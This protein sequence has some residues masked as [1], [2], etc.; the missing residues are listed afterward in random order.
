MFCSE[1]GN[2][3]AEGKA[4]CPRCGA[5]QPVTQTPPP[6]QPVGGTQAQYPQTP[7][8]QQLNPYPPPMGPPPGPPSG[9]GKRRK[10]WT[11]LAIVGAVVFILVAVFV[12]GTVIY[13]RHDDQNTAKERTCQANQRTIDGAI[14]T[15]M[16][17]DPQ[18]RYPSSMQDMVDAG[19][20][21]N[22]PTC[23]SGGK[24]IWKKSNGSDPPTISCTVH[25]SYGF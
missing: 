4:F 5:K 3:I 10:L 20:M 24:Y 2:E 12:I 17:A 18:E 1:C 21:K 6:A 7:P 19:V 22:I 9:R 11:V 14:E 25:P 16:A 23:P 8:G 15:Y 13:I